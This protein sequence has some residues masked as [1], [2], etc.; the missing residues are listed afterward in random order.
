M[1]LSAFCRIKSE[2][3]YKGVLV[4]LMIPSV[5]ICR[6]QIKMGYPLPLGTL[7]LAWAPSDDR[8]TMQLCA[9][10]TDRRQHFVKLVETF[11]RCNCQLLYTAPPL[12]LCASWNEVLCQFLYFWRS[13]AFGWEGACDFRQNIDP[14]VANLQKETNACFK[15]LQFRQP[16]LLTF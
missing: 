11:W 16:N 7:T 3:R 2:L 5:F 1:H 6:G 13:W 14:Q 4:P 15:K 12:A 8:R 10:V 9:W